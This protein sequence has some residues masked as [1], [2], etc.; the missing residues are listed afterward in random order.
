MVRPATQAAVTEKGVKGL[1]GRW[2]QQGLGDQPNQRHRRGGEGITRGKQKRK[3][4]EMRRE[5]NGILKTPGKEE[6][7]HEVR[8]PNVSDWK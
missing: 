6:V 3:G 7:T 1:R 2:S 5:G 4:V 8:F